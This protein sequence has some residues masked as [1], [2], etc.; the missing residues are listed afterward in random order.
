M[1]ELRRRPSVTEQ[2]PL[3]GQFEAGGERAGPNYRRLGFIGGAGLALAGVS[4]AAF[5]FFGSTSQETDGNNTP[6]RKPA[7]TASASPGETEASPEVSESAPAITFE[8]ATYRM[9]GKELSFDGYVEAQQIPSDLSGKEA[10][11][12]FFSTT[13]T[14]WVQ[15]SLTKGD[16]AQYEKFVAEPDEEGTVYDGL[17]AA[18]I[19]FYDR[20]FMDA[21]IGQGNDLRDNLPGRDSSP[22]LEEILL[23]HARATVA[24]VKTQDE[25]TPFKGEFEV[26]GFNHAT[27]I[28]LHGNHETAFS[29]IVKYTDNG[30]KNSSGP[31]LTPL[32]AFGTKTFKAEGAMIENEETKSWKMAAVELSEL[33]DYE[34]SKFDPAS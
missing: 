29:V 26:L 21:V 34:T 6:E 4:A 9:D 19:N 27:E 28:D 18:A 20:A 23:I 24:Y 33:N 12:E 31:E 17:Q 22:L 16:A 25:T 11:T 10:V 2:Q 7:A 30:G 3:S 13:L 32:G 1:S 15:S 14:N 8:S 5:G